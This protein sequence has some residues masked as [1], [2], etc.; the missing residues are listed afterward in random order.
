MSKRAIAIA[1]L[2]PALFCAGLAHAASEE[3]Q[4]REQLRQ[5][6]LQLRELQDNQAAAGSQQSDAAQQRDALKKELDST[7]AR[8]RA[9][10]GGGRKVRELQAS[11][12]QSKAETDKANLALQQAQAQLG[13][14][15][16]AYAKA[17]DQVRALTTDRDR[18]Q[19]SL[20]KETAVVASCQAKNVQLYVLSHQI[21]DAYARVNLGAVMVTREPFLGLKRVQLENAVQRDEDKLYDAQCD[22]TPPPAPQAAASSSPARP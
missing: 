22:L 13:Q 3:D 12:V 18:L 2:A 9:A 11:L 19:A 1:L 4:L 16:D 7:K 17:A 6:V 21:L 10:N 20:T 8:L 14:Y 15:K 5:T